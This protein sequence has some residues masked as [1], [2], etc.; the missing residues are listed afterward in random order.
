MSDL[1]PE[2]P[3]GGGATAQPGTVAELG[4]DDLRDGRGQ[5]DHRTKYPRGAWIWVA[6]EGTYALLIFLICGLHLVMIAGPPGHL[7]PDWADCW[8]FALIADEPPRD[9]NV[10][11]LWSA[12]FFGGMAGSNL[13]A[14]KWLYHSWATQWWHRDRVFWRL[15]VPIQGGILAVFV[16]FMAVAG[17][18][19]G[20][21]ENV[22]GRYLTA[23]GFGFAVGLLADNVISAVARLIRVTLHQFSNAAA[24]ALGRDDSGKPGRDT[25]RLEPPASGAGR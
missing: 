11:S 6:C 22:F 16:G 5:G 10:V 2:A 25:R 8:L 18:I 3:G 13:F 19:P 9:G 17:I 15:Y 12:V 4:D 20:I 23:A 7:G 14:T 24:R 21:G 1:S